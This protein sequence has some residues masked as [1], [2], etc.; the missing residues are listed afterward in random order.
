MSKKI[1]VFLFST[2]KTS[3]IED[4]FHY[5]KKNYISKWIS[6]SGINAIF[7]II[8]NCFNYQV[9]IVWFA[10]TYSALIVFLSKI[11]NKKSIII[12]GGADIIFDKNLKYGLLQ[13]KWKFPIIKFALNN[14][15]YLIASS[16]YIEKNIIKICKKRPKNLFVIYP[17]VNIDLWKISNK[18]NETKNILTVAVCNNKTRFNIKGIDIFINLAKKI[19]DVNFTIVGIDKKLLK[20]ITFPKNVLVI[21]KLNQ[22]ELLKYYNKANIYCQFSRRESF[23]LAC[24]E[25]IL[26]G[27]VPIVSNVGG[28]KEIVQNSDLVVDLNNFSNIIKTVKQT[29]NESKKIDLKKFQHRFSSF[30]RYKKLDTIIHK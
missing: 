11:F 9:Y 25:A 22:K 14:A 24:A 20:N 16:K 3:F 10:S 28:L 30:S 1:K 7:H 27:C 23:G 21:P 2:F 19:K 26:C 5:I 6:D 15:D 13:K 18:K 8:S 4:D 12:V 17:G 29:L